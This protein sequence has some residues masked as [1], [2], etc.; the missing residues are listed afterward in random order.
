MGRSS[1]APAS[2]E[3]KGSLYDRMLAR[4]TEPRVYILAP[5]ILSPSMTISREQLIADFMGIATYI[6]R[7]DAFG[8]A[9]TSAPRWPTRDEAERAVNAVLG[10]LAG[11]TPT[12]GNSDPVHPATSDTSSTFSDFHPV[13]E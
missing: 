3:G 2:T 10:V 1:T 8:N 9:A 6:C 5:G 12:A 13:G 4:S 11:V 7:R